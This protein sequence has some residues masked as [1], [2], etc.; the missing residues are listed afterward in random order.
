MEHHESTHHREYGKKKFDFKLPLKPEQIGMIAIG[1]AV[2]FLLGW[3]VLGLFD[4]DIEC[5]VDAQCSAD[6]MCHEGACVQSGGGYYRTEDPNGKFFLT[7]PDGH[8]LKKT[9]ATQVTVFPD[10]SESVATPLPVMN[11]LFDESGMVT[12]LLHEGLDWEHF[13][14]LVESF[15]FKE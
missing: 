15:R 12:F 2:G 6:L 4:K 8:T 10:P 3:V 13:E 14:P 1:L 11:I 9:S 7:V 5:E